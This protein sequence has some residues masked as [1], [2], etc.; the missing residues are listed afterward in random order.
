[1]HGNVY[2]HKCCV[3]IAIISTK[4]V[5]NIVDLPP[6]LKITNLKVAF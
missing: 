3:D 2:K 4:S 1:M 6:E 5:Y